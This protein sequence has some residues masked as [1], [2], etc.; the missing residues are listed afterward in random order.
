[1]LPLGVSGG[2]KPAIILLG[3]HLYSA[4]TA[5]SR[6]PRIVAVPQTTKGQGGE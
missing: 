1:M 6:G 5:E 3:G 2:F 4:A